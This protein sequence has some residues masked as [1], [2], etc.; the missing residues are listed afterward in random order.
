MMHFVVGR[1]PCYEE[2]RRENPTD[3]FSGTPLYKNRLAYQKRS[4]QTCV[5]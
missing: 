4:T 5:T 3:S 1:P 2:L